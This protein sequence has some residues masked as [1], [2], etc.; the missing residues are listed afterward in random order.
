[1]KKSEKPLILI[2]DDEVTN[3]QLLNVALQSYFRIVPAKNGREALER[4]EQHQPRVVLLDLRMPEMDGWEVLEELRKSGKLAALRIII[5]SAEGEGVDKARALEM[6]VRDYVTKP[7][8]TVELIARVR[9]ALA[10]RT[11]AEFALTIERHVDAALAGIQCHFGKITE[12]VNGFPIA[13]E[14]GDELLRAEEWFR[15]FLLWEKL[16]QAQLSLNERVSVQKILNE[17]IFESYPSQ[18]IIMQPGINQG[19]QIAGNASWLRMLLDNILKN[20]IC[21]TP[22]GS[23]VRVSFVGEAEEL[24]IAIANKGA[25]IAAEHI[26]YLFTPFP[27]KMGGERP[28]FD[29]NLAVAA[30]VAE[31]HGGRIEHRQ[32][33]GWTTI[34]ATLPIAQSEEAAR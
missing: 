21:H 7:F 15:M 4:I 6:G 28:A 19:S 11:D 29:M 26:P 24:T 22:E 3:L 20:A 31:R 23:E 34:A 32:D 25:P 12:V 14:V 18:D 27:E 13:K 17:L 8:D 33:G 9:A 5:I 2:V 1:M 16:Q 10:S 30:V